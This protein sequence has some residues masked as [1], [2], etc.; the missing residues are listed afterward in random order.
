M[1]HSPHMNASQ[2]QTSGTH[3]PPGFAIEPRGGG[4]R[5]AASVDIKHN[6]CSEGRRCKRTRH[7]GGS[8]GPESK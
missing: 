8:G 6:S 5:G 3:T 2:L 7:R 4:D 1:A